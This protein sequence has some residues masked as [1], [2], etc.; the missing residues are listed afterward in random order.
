MPVEYGLRDVESD[1]DGPRGVAG[2]VDGHAE[3]E[4]HLATAPYPSA[5]P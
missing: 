1:R 5:A 4:P 3:A 2:V